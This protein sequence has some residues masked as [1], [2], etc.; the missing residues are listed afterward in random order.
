LKVRVYR[1]SRVIIDFPSLHVKCD[2]DIFDNQTGK[3]SLSSLPIKSKNKF[4]GD[5]CYFEAFTSQIGRP[6]KNTS[7]DEQFRD[8]LKK[9]ENEIAFWSSG[10]CF[11]L[12]LGKT[13][14]KF[15]NVEDDLKK[16]K[17]FEKCW[18]FG[19][20]TKNF[21]KISNFQE[22]E[23][24]IDILMYKRI[25]NIKVSNFEFNAELYDT[26][27]ADKIFE[28]LPIKSKIKIKGKYLY[29]KIN[30]KDKIFPE[31]NMERNNLE[32]GEIG[33]D[34]NSSKLKLNFLENDEKSKN[35]KPLNLFAKIIMN[36]SMIKFT[37]LNDNDI[38]EIKILNS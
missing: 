35:I 2:V 4:F 13:V 16:L 28:I 20:I 12:G 27:T 21:D 33:F 11:I 32:Y 17:L 6:K 3:F 15:E 1:P 37:E 34:I 29:S 19:K 14:Y 23:T 5:S 9:D 25:I 38:L 26:T 7:L 24:D 22:R 8:F 30:I 18:V 36:V 10:N 31:S